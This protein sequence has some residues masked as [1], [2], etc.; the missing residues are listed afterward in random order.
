MCRRFQRFLGAVPHASLNDDLG[1][2]QMLHAVSQGDVRHKME[3]EKVMVEIRR[4]HRCHFNVHNLLQ[5]GKEAGSVVILIVVSVY[6]NL[7]GLAPFLK[8]IERAFTADF[9]RRVH[10]DVVI[11]RVKSSLGGGCRKPA[12]D[13]PPSRRLNV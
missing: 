4:G 13:F 8:L 3:N 9:E 6:R 12:D 1:R 11:T 2:I 5:S 10:Q 7:D